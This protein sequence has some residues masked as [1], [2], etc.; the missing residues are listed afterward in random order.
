MRK[1]L[2]KINPGVAIG[3]VT[4]MA[5]ALLMSLFVPDMYAFA[6]DGK[7]TTWNSNAST[8]AVGILGIIFIGL[9]VAG[10]VE[11]AKGGDNAKK[12]FISAL[13]VFVIGGLV[14][15]AGNF[16][17]IAGI[18]QPVAQSASEGAADVS[19]ELLG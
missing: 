15:V 7:T 3:L 14:M 5:T 17:T 1:F 19:G 16:S 2:S 13:I 9:L 11:T 4:F 10:A 12:L 8:I 18:F 6:A